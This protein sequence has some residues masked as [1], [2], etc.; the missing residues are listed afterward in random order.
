[1][2]SIQNVGADKIRPILDRVLIRIEKAKMGFNKT[3]GGI[4]IPEDIRHTE[5][6]IGVVVAVGP[7]KVWDTPP[8]KG[9]F[10]ATYVRPGDRALFALEGAEPLTWLDTDEYHYEMLRSEIHIL[11]TL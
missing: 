5:Q 3:E 7:G 9:E 2:S 6:C 1:M 11:G 10:V 8:Y 4:F